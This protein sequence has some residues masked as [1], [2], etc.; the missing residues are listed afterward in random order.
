MEITEKVVKEMS[1]KI[2]KGIVGQFWKESLEES[3]EVP[4]T[5]IEDF[6]LMQECIF[7]QLQGR[8]CRQKLGRK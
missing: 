6:F 8:I 1:G 4:G 3:G 2:L 7:Q 5:V